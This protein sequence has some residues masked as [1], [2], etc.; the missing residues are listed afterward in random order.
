MSGRGKG[1]KGLGKGGQRRHRKV[2]EEPRGWI[3]ELT[4]TKQHKQQRQEAKQGN[5]T[6]KGIL[7]G[8]EKRRMYEAMKVK[9][10]GV[11]FFE[12]ANVKNRSYRPRNRA[13]GRA[14][15]IQA[16]LLPMKTQKPAK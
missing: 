15:N 4:A 16:E 5:N 3:D 12:Y 11:H 6:P 10:I 8:K 7:T 13:C 14:V 2:L 9:K 1:G